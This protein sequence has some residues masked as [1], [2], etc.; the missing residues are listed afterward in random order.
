M[1]ENNKFYF[2]NELHG[3]L[4]DLFGI[5]NTIIPV[6]NKKIL[7]MYNNEKNKKISPDAIHKLLINIFCYD[8]YPII[9]ISYFD[10]LLLNHIIHIS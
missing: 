2:K 10:F 7:L 6:I 5:P 3:R 1:K 9:R 8:Y 4:F